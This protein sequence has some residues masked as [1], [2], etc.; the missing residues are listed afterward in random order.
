M[1]MKKSC[2]A[3]RAVSS[4]PGGKEGSCARLLLDR[5]S[6]PSFRFIT[7]RESLQTNPPSPFRLTDIF[8]YLDECSASS[9][10]LSLFSHAN[11]PRSNEQSHGRQR[12]TNRSI[13]VDSRNN[14][15]RRANIRVSFAILPSFSTA[16]AGVICANEFLRQI[17]QSLRLF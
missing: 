12:Q 15:K 16:T 11:R 17:I 13:V 2:A 14:S 3:P 6:L 4:R 7:H 8:R 10:F 5:L 9:T 1:L